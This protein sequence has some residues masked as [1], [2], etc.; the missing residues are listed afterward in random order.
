MK[1]DI[2]FDFGPSC[3]CY[4]TCRSWREVRKRIREY[5]PFTAVRITRVKRH[6][7]SWRHDRT[8]AR[9][10]LRALAS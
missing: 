3:R 6:W 8:D 1:F 9:H 10:G 4:L 5:A 2:R 7:G